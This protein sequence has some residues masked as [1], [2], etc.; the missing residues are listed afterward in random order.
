VQ[1]TGAEAALIPFDMPWITMI[2]LLENTQG[3]LLPGG[4]AELVNFESTKST[5]AYQNRIHKIMEW[6]KVR[7]DKDK[8]YYPVWG[9]CLG[10]E[11]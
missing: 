3:I 4:A 1:Q 8:I 2:H 7:N 6:V 9:T 11:E 10:F 5:S